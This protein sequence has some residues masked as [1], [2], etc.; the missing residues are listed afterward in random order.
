VNVTATA[1]AAAEREMD[2]GRVEYLPVDPLELLHERVV[3]AVRDV[4]FYRELYAP[5]LPIPDAPDR[6]FLDWFASLPVVSKSQL[7]RAGTDA[8][9]NPSY[10]LPDLIRKPTS[11]STGIA[12]ILY[13]HK[14]VIDLRKWRFQR[15]HQVLVGEP[16]S[17]LVFVFPWDFV[18]RSPR[19]ESQ[20]ATVAGRPG[21]ASERPRDD[22]ARAHPR[23]ADGPAFSAAPKKS[24]R[25][26]VE[27]RADPDGAPTT[28][29]GGPPREPIADRPFTVNSLLPAEQLYEAF[30]QLRPTT[31]IGFASTIGGLGRWMVEH[32]RSL[33]SVRQ[34]WTTSEVL[35][36]ESSDALRAALGCE[37]LTIYASNE[38]GFMAWQAL[39]EGPLCFDSDRM[40]VETLQRTRPEPAGPDELARIVATD[41]LNDTMP[42]IRYDIGD[43]AHPAPPMRVTDDLVAGAIRRLHGKE[44]D[45][46]ET[47]A[48]EPVGTFHL[49]GTIKDCL[50]DAQYRF[51]AVGRGQFV[52]QYVPGVGF[53]GENLAPATEALRMILGEAAVI[54]AQAVDAIEREP[55]GKLRPVVSLATARGA[56][57]IRLAA[58]LGV[59]PFLA[60]DVRDTAT[61]IVGGALASVLPGYRRADAL[62]EGDELYADLAIDSLRFVE[63]VA[64]LEDQLQVE[65][66]DED[67]LDEDLITTGDL[68]SFVARKLMDGAARPSEAV[69]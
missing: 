5:F 11:G 33:P 42:L 27:K 24:R 68:V 65:I 2:G 28:D 21:E 7:Q 35:P 67:L 64:E 38:F 69:G 61:A 55:T 40:F 51:I 53:A 20:A 12:F 17:R 58:H 32:G 1:L 34:V 4:P 48:G 8:L 25:R 23:Q 47:L 62:D 41:L 44:A 13:L 59:L 26:R 29:G 60:D 31:L 3:S 50:P 15:P 10:S 30:A 49:L 52:L 16:A 63:L 14:T 22:G 54:Q 46:I 57:R 9:R 6:Q 37:P 19:R 45:V 18:A 56:H 39:P 66:D 43:V 36:P